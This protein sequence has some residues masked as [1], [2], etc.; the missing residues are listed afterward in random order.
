MS[1]QGGGLGMPEGNKPAFD[2]GWGGGD[3]PD[4]PPETFE[5]WTEVDVLRAIGRELRAQTEHLVKIRSYTGFVVAV[6]IVQAVAVL[7]VAA[8]NSS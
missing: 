6:I 4:Q 1:D 2:A 8:M 3:Q 7:L 5:N